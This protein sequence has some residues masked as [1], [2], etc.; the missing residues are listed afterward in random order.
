MVKSIKN[1]QHIDNN[2]TSFRHQQVPLPFLFNVEVQFVHKNLMH[3]SSKFKSLQ[4]F[5]EVRVR[6]AIIFPRY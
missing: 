1:V 2:G 6:E 4:I 5:F 3:Y